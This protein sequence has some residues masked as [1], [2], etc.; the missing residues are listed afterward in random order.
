MRIRLN[1][2][3]LVSVEKRRLKGDLIVSEVPN[4]EL[5]ERRGQ[6]LLE[7]SVVIRF[8]LKEW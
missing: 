8:K 1:D 4:R 6:A 2:L 5:Q 3:G 7:R